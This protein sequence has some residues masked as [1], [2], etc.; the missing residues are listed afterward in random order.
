MPRGTFL[1]QGEDYGNAQTHRASLVVAHRARGTRACARGLRRIGRIRRFERR[2]GGSNGAVSNRGCAGGDCGTLTGRAHGRRRRLRELLRGRLVDHAAAAE[3][4][5]RRD[6]AGRRRGSISRN[7]TDLSDL[8]SVTSLAPGNF[9]NGKIR[10]DYT[11]AEVSW[12]RTAQIVQATAVGENGEP[13]G[14]TDLE[15]RLANRDHS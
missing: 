11:N 9:V 8:L 6:A 5:F 14:M 10:I 3:R 7:S 1:R 12:R 4:R 13:L 15:V 2:H